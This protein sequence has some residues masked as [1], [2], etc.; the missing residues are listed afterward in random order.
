[1]N[2]Q[3]SLEV[4]YGASMALIK[5]CIKTK[6]TAVR[7]GSGCAFIDR[8]VTQMKKELGY[9]PFNKYQTKKLTKKVE[10]YEQIS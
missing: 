4:S 2:Y 3:L 10:I 7:H 9:M 5:M 6:L 8:I 1:M